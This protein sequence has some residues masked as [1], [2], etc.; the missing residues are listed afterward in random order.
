MGPFACCCPCCCI[1]CSSISCRAQHNTHTA[2]FRTAAQPAYGERD[3][4]NH[5]GQFAA[6]QFALKGAAKHDAQ[7]SP[8]PPSWGS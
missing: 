8:D 6:Q 4:G 2:T 3:P 7:N 1:I 5:S